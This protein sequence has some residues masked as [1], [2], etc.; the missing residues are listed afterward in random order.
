[1][2]LPKVPL[3]DLDN[4]NQRR[5]LRETINKVLDHGF[6]D[7]RVDTTAETLAGVTIVNPAFGP[8]DFRRYGA[9]ADG[10]TD[11]TTLILDV[12][13]AMA[14]ASV[15]F[16]SCQDMKFDFNQVVAAIPPRCVLKD[17]SMINAWNT[18]G[19]RQKSTGFYEGYDDT[20]INDYQFVISSGHNAA[21]MTDNRGT[22]SS[23]SGQLRIAMWMWTS[24]R[25]TKEPSQN[26][27]RGIGRVEW[28]KIP[29]QNKW[30]WVMR[31]M[32][33]WAAADYELWY[34]GKTYA[35]GSTII[36]GS[37]V[38]VTPAGGVSGAGPLNGG[39]IGSVHSDG[40]ITDWTVIMDNID[41]AIFVINE[42][43]ELAMH[44][45]PVAGVVAYLKADPDGPA[46]GVANL[47]VEASNVSQNASLRLIPTNS[48]GGLVDTPYLI[49]ADTVGLRGVNSAATQAG[50]AFT[51]A[52]MFELAQNGL[53][54]IVAADGDTTPSVAGAG[55]LILRNTGATSITVLDDGKATARVQLFFENSNTTLVHNGSTFLLK[56]AANVNPAVF[57]VIWMEK[58]SGS[59]A[60][61]ETGRNF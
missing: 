8:Y 15:M 42:N 7:S 37:F 48:G 26:G 53:A 11:N 23:A 18:G 24:G 6:D 52:R 3:T 31:R 21:I 12:F 30:W 61:F 45:A 27:M 36:E 25:F 32:V 50:F 9:V 2:P 35:A 22:A 5:R 10:T 16:F 55:R 51:D 29:G 49:A 44:T 54:E 19:F 28:S 13:T 17:E 38:F 39:A 60:W 33:P 4:I 46:G 41:S 47:W 56:G 14:S 59:A 57:N 40:G 34:A 20:A 58:Y 43:G 1:M